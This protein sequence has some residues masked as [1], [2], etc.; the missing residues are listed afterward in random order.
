LATTGKTLKLFVRRFP[1][2]KLFNLPAVQRIGENSR[3]AGGIIAATPIGGLCD[4]AVA[5]ARRYKNEETKMK[6]QTY[7][8]CRDGRCG[9]TDCPSCSPHYFRGGVQVDDLQENQPSETE[10]VESE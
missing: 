2:E 4:Q 3:S 9:A 1:S 5:Q 7:T 8:A 10:T 6:N